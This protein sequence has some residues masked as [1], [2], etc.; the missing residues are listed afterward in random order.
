MLKALGMI[1]LAVLLAGCD[2]VHMRGWFGGKPSAE[3][4]APTKQT[5]KRKV[6]HYRSRVPAHA[7]PAAPVVAPIAPPIVEPAPQPPR[8]E[9]PAPPAPVVEAPKPAPV[10]PKPGKSWRA[11]DWFLRH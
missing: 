6:R 9:T 11:W 4:A 3:T 1:V 2:P 5:V 7:E 10:K 8:V